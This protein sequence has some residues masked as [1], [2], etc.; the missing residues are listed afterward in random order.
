MLMELVANF[1]VSEEEATRLLLRH[2]SA[3]IAP[4]NI[5]AMEEATCA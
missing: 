4:T 3:K 5:I 1:L 2:D